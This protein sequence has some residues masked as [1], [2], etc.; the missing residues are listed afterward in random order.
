MSKIPPPPGTSTPQDDAEALAEAEELTGQGSGRVPRASARRARST[1]KRG[2]RRRG[3]GS[4]D[5]DFDSMSDDFEVPD[6]YEDEP[7]DV[8][9]MVHVCVCMR[10]CWV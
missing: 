4:E 5:D 10:V 1:F 9:L 2:R 7:E 6:D 3:D 8:S